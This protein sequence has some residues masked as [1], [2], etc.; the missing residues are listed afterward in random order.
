MLRIYIS[1]A[2]ADKPYLDTLLKWLQPLKEKYF[3]RIWHNPAPR[4]ASD[5]PYQWDDMLDNLENAHIYLFLTSY[6]SLSAAHIGQE[7]IPRAVERHIK[8]GDDLVRVYPVL[9]SPSQ[10]KKHS[11]LASYKPLGPP[12]TLAELKPDENGYLALIEQLEEIVDTLRRNWM[13][14]HRRLGLPLDE[15]SK[16]VLPSGEGASGLKPIP[17]WVSVALLFVIFYLITTWYFSGCAPRMYFMYT[18]EYMPYQPLPERFLREN[19]LLEPLDVP[20]PPPDDTVGRRVR[21]VE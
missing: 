3:L 15:F 12:K 14:E 21:L 9:L 8:Y 2:P 20:F 1:Y 7:E 13:E 10:W 5:L 6:H 11:G 17:G 19:P 18:P 16:P 4:Y